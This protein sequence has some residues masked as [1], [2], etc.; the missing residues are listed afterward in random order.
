[1]VGEDCSTWEDEGS[2][3]SEGE[4]DTTVVNGVSD[5]G[6]NVGMLEKEYDG[7]SKEVC[8]GSTPEGKSGASEEDTEADVEIGVPDQKIGLLE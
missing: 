7:V 3:S 6:E 8:S 1:M 2:R 5:P 4:A